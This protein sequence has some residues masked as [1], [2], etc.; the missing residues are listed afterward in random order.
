MSITTI[1]SI[2]IGLISIPQ[3]PSHH[4]ALL[5]TALTSALAAYSAQRPLIQGVATS[6]PDVNTGSDEQGDYI[7]G[8]VPLSTGIAYATMI[9]LSGE[10]YKFR[11][12]SLASP[13]AMVRVYTATNAEITIWHPTAHDTSAES[14]PAHHEA[15]IALMCASFYLNAVALAEP[16]VRRA[17]M[18]QSIAASYYG[19]ATSTLQTLI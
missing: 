14:W 19:R 1:K 16:D 10:Q 7:E 9:T 8:L 3:R 11:L 13:N 12:V 15:I 5:D 2:A 18:I 4:E 6:I 17:E